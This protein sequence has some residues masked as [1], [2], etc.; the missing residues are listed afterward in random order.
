MWRRV[1]ISWPRDNP[2]SPDK[3]TRSINLYFSRN[4]LASPSW[5]WLWPVRKQNAARESRLT[6]LPNESW[7]SAL[8]CFALQVMH[9]IVDTVRPPNHTQLHLTYNTLLQLGKVC[10]ANSSKSTNMILQSHLKVLHHT[11]DSSQLCPSKKSSTAFKTWDQT[12]CS[13]SSSSSSCCINT[14]FGLDSSWG[15]DLHA[16]PHHWQLTPS[17]SSIM[18]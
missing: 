18:I 16:G 9:P 12:L 15:R 5:C 4:A 11:A 17:C 10:S 13:N 2:P 8:F 3:L 1:R 14:S 7:Q 6:R